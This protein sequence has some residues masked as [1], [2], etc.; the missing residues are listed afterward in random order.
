MNVKSERTENESQSSPRS[1][2]TSEEGLTDLST[3]ATILSSS[4]E[5][6]GRL[7]PNFQ[8]LQCKD[9][10]SLLLQMD[11]PPEYDTTFMAQVCNQLWDNMDMLQ[12]LGCVSLQL[13]LFIWCKI[14]NN[15]IF[16]DFYRK[17]GQRVIIRKELVPANYETFANEV[18][19]KFQSYMLQCEQLWLHATQGWSFF[20]NFLWSLQRPFFLWQIYG[21]LQNF[22]PYL[23]K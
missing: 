23:A 17:I 19:C 8:S 14:I 10:K 12:R 5:T 15:F 4:R 9:L 16:Q 2:A 6:K 3:R 21:I 1:A 22:Y 11:A 7:K 13:A 18:L 20:Y